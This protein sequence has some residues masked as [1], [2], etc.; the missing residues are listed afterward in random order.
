MRC[1][2]LILVISLG[3]RI[4]SAQTPSIEVKNPGFRNESELSIVSSEG[5]SKSQSVSAI[6]KNGYMWS[7]NTLKSELRHLRSKAASRESAKSESAALRYERILSERLSAYAGQGVESDRY[8][9]IKLRLNSDLGVKHTLLSSK[10]FSVAAEAGYRYT[11]ETHV[12]PPD[13]NGHFGRLYAEANGTLTETTS[14]KLWLEYLPNFTQPDGYFLNA[15]PS[16]AVMLNAI[17]S[18]KIAYLMKYNNSPPPAT[19]ERLDNVFTT[20]LVAKI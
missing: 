17:L 3:A 4:S 11:N 7:Q 2:L 10:E 12:V 15:E 13:S 14:G 8:A 19:V 18:L 1:C 9:G 20:S 6:Q 16:V 5:N